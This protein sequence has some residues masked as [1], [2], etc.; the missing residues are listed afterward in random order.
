M[1]RRRPAHLTYDALYQF[2]TVEL[3]CREGSHCE[4]AGDDLAGEWVTNDATDCGLILRRPPLRR[5]RIYR[6]SPLNSVLIA[7]TGGEAVHYSFLVLDGH[8][9]E[10]SPV[11]LTDHD[12][13]NIVVGENLAEFLRLGLNTGYFLSGYDLCDPEGNWTN[14][15]AAQRFETKATPV[16]GPPERFDFQLQRLGEHFGLEPLSGVAERLAELQQRYQPLIEPAPPRS[17]GLPGTDAGNTEKILLA[18]RLALFN[19]GDRVVWDRNATGRIASVRARV[20]R[21]TARHVEVAAEDGTG[22]EVVRRVSPWNL[23][24]Q[25]Q[26]TR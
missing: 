2:F 24:H 23:R 20:L 19:A 21:V 4:F 15:E 9:S 5:E 10:L 1:A 13:G 16:V 7:H 17:L 6:Y 12:W 25:E 18:A 22:R 14:P 3:R 11:V 8:W 26:F